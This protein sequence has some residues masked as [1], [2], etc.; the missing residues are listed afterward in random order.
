MN[1]TIGI[2]NDSQTAY[3]DALNDTM[4]TYVLNINATAG[5]Y[6]VARDVI[7]NTSATSW[8][9][10][11]FPRFTELVSQIGNWT[12]DR[13]DYWNTST[14]LIFTTNITTTGNITSDFFFGNGS[15]LTSLTESQI[16]DLA[17]NGTTD[18]NANTICSGT[19]TYLD[20]EGNCDELNAVYEFQLGTEAGLYAVLSDVSDFLQSLV[21]DTTPQLGGYLDTNGNNIGSTSDEIENIYVATNS[22]IFFGDGQ[23]AFIVYNGTA[24]IISG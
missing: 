17:H 20:G 18:T 7:A 16:V 22:K 9:D 19:T 14:N 11:L 3:T 12:L 4:G 1:E 13:T 24:L 10:L 8:V 5:V 2:F 15:Q 21:Q 6:A 23:E